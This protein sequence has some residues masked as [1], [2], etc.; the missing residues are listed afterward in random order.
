MLNSIFKSIRHKII[1]TVYPH[2]M[3]C[4]LCSS[5]VDVQP[6]YGMCELCMAG[7]SM[8]SGKVEFDYDN[9]YFDSAVAPFYYRTP[10]KE[11][12]HKFKYSNHRYISKSLARFMVDSINEMAW[13]GFDVAVPVPLH[14]GREKK[15]GFNQAALLAMETAK[16]LEIDFD[17]NVLMRVKDTKSQTLLD[18]DGRRQNVED[19]FVLQEGKTVKDRKILLFDDV[20]TSGATVNACAKTLREAGAKSVFVVS[21]CTREIEKEF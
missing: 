16:Y 3:A 20:I 13:T 17:Q 18:K 7:L 1:R 4:V 5:E 12:I 14:G 15:R 19:A 21:A 8:A 9:C 2:D 6:E 10:I 11:L